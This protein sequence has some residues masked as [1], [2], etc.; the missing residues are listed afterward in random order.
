MNTTLYNYLRDNYGTT[1]DPINN[2]LEE[3]YTNHSDK[4]TEK[5]LEKS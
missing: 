3:K 2:A 5:G 4:T 1:D